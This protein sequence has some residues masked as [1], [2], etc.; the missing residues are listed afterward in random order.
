MTC[1]PVVAPSKVVR[2]QAVKRLLA[3]EPMLDGPGLEVTV[4]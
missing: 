4:G 2:I 3:P 1:L